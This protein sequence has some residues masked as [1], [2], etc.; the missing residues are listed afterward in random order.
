MAILEQ[1]AVV[2]GQDEHDRVRK[3]ERGPE[4]DRQKVAGATAE[5]AKPRLDE[6]PRQK[7]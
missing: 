3:Y 4:M 6:Y 2:R 7:E 1:G 5:E